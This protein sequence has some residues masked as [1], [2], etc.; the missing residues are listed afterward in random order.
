MFIH[1]AFHI[2]AFT[3]RAVPHFVIR[4][5]LTVFWLEHQDFHEMCDRQPRS[6]RC[7]SS[8]QMTINRAG[9]IK[10]DPEKVF[11]FVLTI[12]NVNFHLKDYQSDY[13]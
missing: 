13:V 10:T 12:F 6:R 5:L 3:F 11:Y 7:T 4:Y 2:Y 1:T 8:V 9:R